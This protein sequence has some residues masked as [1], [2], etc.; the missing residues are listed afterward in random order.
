MEAPFTDK[1][2]TWMRILREVEEILWARDGDLL[3]DISAGP[4]GDLVPHPGAT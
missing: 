1:V 2:L 4:A 3:P